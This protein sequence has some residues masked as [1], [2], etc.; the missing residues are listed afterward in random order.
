[1]HLSLLPLIFGLGEPWQTRLQMP[2]MILHLNYP[3]S[4]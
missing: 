1:L 2:S 3:D 4:R